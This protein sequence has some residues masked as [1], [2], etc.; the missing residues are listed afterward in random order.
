MEE[1]RRFTRV[2]L[3]APTEMHQGA[4]SWQVQL[5]DISLNGIAVAQP[6]PW[7]GDYSHPFSFKIGLPQDGELEVFGHL[8]HAAAGTLGFQLEHLEPEQM[9]PLVQLLASKMDQTSIK[10]EIALLDQ[11]PTGQN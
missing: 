10:D 5:I 3:D 4:A 2:Q 7:D 1:Q 11:A 9:E 8:V 6:E